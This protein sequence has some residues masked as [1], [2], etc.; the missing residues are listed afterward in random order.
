MKKV[1]FILLLFLLACGAAEERIETRLEAVDEEFYVHDTRAPRIRFDEAEREGLTLPDLSAGAVLWVAE[2]P[3]G[4]EGGKPSILVATDE[5]GIPVEE[6][7]WVD[8]KGK[9]DFRSGESWTV[10]Q[11]EDY[12]RWFETGVVSLTYPMAGPAGEGEASFRALLNVYAG[13]ARFRIYPAEGRTGEFAAAPIRFMIYDGDRN[14]LYETS[15]PL[16]IDAD[17]NGEF[18]GNRNSVELYSMEDPFLLGGAAYRIGSV[19][20]DGSSVT[21]VASD[22]TPEPRVPLMPGDNA[23]DFTL[24]GLDGTELT[25]SEAIA[26]GPALLAY[27]ATW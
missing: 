12:D 15:D 11:Y 24:P 26:G 9:G 19:S 6:R 17:G 1:S 2:L 10:S 18:D 5:E 27:W 21:V 14:G 4:P 16:I 23:P 13:G 7:I 22:E 3:Y 8:G 25:L 20:P